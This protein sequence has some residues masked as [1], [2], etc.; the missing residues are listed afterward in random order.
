MREFEEKYKL[1]CLEYDD[2]K[3]QMTENVSI[4]RSIN[5]YILTWF[6]S[7]DNIFKSTTRARV[8]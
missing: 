8:D 1:L 4:T 2:F 3:L 7:V 6:L 5:T